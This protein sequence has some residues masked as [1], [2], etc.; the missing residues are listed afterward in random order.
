MLDTVDKVVTKIELSPYVKERIK[1]KLEL[2]ESKNVVPMEQLRQLLNFV[3]PNVVKLIKP[4]NRFQ[5]GSTDEAIVLYM[6]A[7]SE[8][9]FENS[10]FNFPYTNESLEQLKKYI[11]EIK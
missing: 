6:K 5:Y 9:M 11:K 4:P 8:C 1:A 2:I 7:S 10:Q 3:C